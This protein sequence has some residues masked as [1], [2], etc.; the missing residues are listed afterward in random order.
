MH[1]PVIL[2]GILL[3]LSAVVPTE[4]RAA[5]NE[6][7]SRRPNILFIMTDQHRWDCVGANGNSQ[8][9]TPNFDRLAAE[10]ANF[11]HAFVNAPV[12][13]PSRASFFTGRY[14]HSHR[15]RVNYTPLDRSEILMQARLRD[16]GYTTASVLYDLQNDP[17]EM[18]NLADDVAHREVVFEMKDR[19]LHWLITAD[20]TDQ[21]AP[22]WLRP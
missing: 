12:C 4:S 20:E 13:V 11:T 5:S 1:R 21:I 6:N 19:L 22:R 7:P 8:I 10:G 15:N 17:L 18:K 9:R 3:I 2:A 16:A 14:P